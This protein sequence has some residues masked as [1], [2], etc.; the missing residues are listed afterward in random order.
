MRFSPVKRQIHSTALVTLSF[1]A[2]ASS[3]AGRTPPGERE[4]DTASAAWWVRPAYC[5]V[6][7]DVG[8][9]ALAVSNFGQFGV[10]NYNSRDCFTR[11][12]IYSC[13]YPRESRTKY[14]YSGELWVGAIVDGDTLVTTGAAEFSPA[15]A[16]Q[17]YPNIYSTMDPSQPEY[18]G[19]ISEEDFEVVYSDTCVRCTSQLD[20]LDSRP[21]RPLGIEVTCRSMAWSYSY[22]DDFVLMDYKI[23]NI[24]TRRLNRLYIGI[25]VDADILTMIEES[26]RRGFEDDLCG[27]QHKQP[28]GYLHPPC[29]ADSDIVNVAW[30]AD[31]DGGL[32]GPIR[33]NPPVVNITATRIIR[34]PRDSMDVSFNWWAWVGG[35]T[36]TFFGP[37]MRSSHRDMLG[38]GYPQGDRDYYH[39]LSN[40]EFDYDQARILDIDALDTV[41]TSAPTQWARN[42]ADGMDSRY[43]LSFGPF[44]LDPD[45]TLP[46]TLAYVGG[47][48]FH[49]DAGNFANLPDKPDFWYT[50]VDFSDLANNATWAEWIYDNPGVDTDSDGYA[51]EFTICNAGDDSTWRCDTLIDSSAQPDT[52]YVFCHWAYDVADT[53]WRRGDGVPDFRGA[54]PPPAPK[55]RVYPSNG[56]I[57]IVWNGA[58]SENTPDVFT[59]D[60][61][62]EGYRVY[63]ARDSRQSSFSV[64]ASFDRQD[65]N[66]YIWDYGRDEFVL[67][68]NPMTLEELRCQFAD[69]CNDTSW[70]PEQFPRTNPLVVDGGPMGQDKVYFFTP[71]DYNRSIMANDPDNATTPIKKAYPDAPRPPVLDVDSIRARYPDGEDTLYLTE[72]GYI[73][74]YEYE[75]TLDGLLP[76]VSYW[77]NVTA[78]DYGS[79]TTG[80]GSLETN[81]A[82]NPQ[83]VYAMDRFDYAAGER[84]E[85]YVYPNPYRG[86]EDY[87]AQG[88]EGRGVSDKPVDRTRRIMFANLPPRCTIRIYSLDGD[89]VRE[90]THDV[91]PNSPVAQLDH[92]DLISRNSQQPVSGLYYWTVEDNLGSVQ[93]GK[94][95]VIL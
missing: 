93:I 19:A 34:T 42:W 94:L 44:V 15:I 5:L 58:L 31:N 20:G 27:F 59:R 70:H 66:R 74:Y 25:F 23:K 46:F 92:W 35:Y 32:V 38:E 60:Q 48:N 87:R 51:G 47:K 69:S 75:Y 68:V 83:E 62:F 52:N 6:E 91:D 29:P 82:L 12:V 71:Q 39:L 95:V 26:A 64:V 17:G 7:H 85:V 53:I 24:G 67:V 88:F 84:G 28:A 36:T 54:M 81:P 45:K 63:V 65:W 41:W 79:P 2:L 50:G 37:Q 40:K 16:P 89:L 33:Y 90:I 77:I 13:E 55:V 43:L 9:M 86:D 61:D 76:T 72:D 21:H 56:K 14:L 73:K 3:L 30:A 80:L 18:E 1:L 11:K 10:G 8:N 78:F 4:R 49:V 22:A 57:R